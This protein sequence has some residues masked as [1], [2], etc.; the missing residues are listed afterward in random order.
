MPMACAAWL[1]SPVLTGVFSLS[2][3]HVTC[4]AG[5]AAWATVALVGD[6][7]EQLLRGRELYGTPCPL[8]PAQEALGG[9]A[10][11]TGLSPMGPMQALAGV[12]PAVQ[13]SYAL[14]SVR[15]LARIY[16]ALERRP[17]VTYCRAR[18][19]LCPLTLAQQP[20]SS[21][22]YWAGMRRA[23]GWSPVGVGL[24]AA[25]HVQLQCLASLASRLRPLLPAEA[26]LAKQLA[27][28]HAVCPQ[29]RLLGRWEL[30]GTA[31][32]PEHIVP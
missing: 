14:G 20:A 6:T 2:G 10:D 28:L 30:Y 17:G 25:T 27:A 11:L 31:R 7:A 29:G 4:D 18:G 3:L 23:L 32:T 9:Y 13:R 15:V 1:C 22:L 12:D 5:D 19:S 21:P 16:V 8:L 26:P 24:R